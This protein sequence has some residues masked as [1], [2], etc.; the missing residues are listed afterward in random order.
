MTSDIMKRIEARKA[1]L[2]K[3][4]LSPWRPMSTAPTHPQERVLLLVPLTIGYT[5]FGQVEGYYASA[6]HVGWRHEFQDGFDACIE[7]FAWRPLHELPEAFKDTEGL[8]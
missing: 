3:A 4:D 5:K 2:L 7:P 6:W 8:G 1:A